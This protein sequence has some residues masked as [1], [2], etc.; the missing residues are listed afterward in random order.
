M[1]GDPL[2][3]KRP[4][5]TCAINYLASMT[6]SNICKNLGISKFIYVSSC[7]VYGSNDYLTNE[8]S[9]INP[10]SIYAKLKSFI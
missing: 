4:K 7:S 10:L 2:C 8:T 6:I 5:K 9:K 1:V 3:E